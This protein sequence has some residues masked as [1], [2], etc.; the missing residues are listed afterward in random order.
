MPVVRSTLTESDTDMRSTQLLTGALAVVATSA[1][2]G[3]SAPSIAHVP[4]SSPSRS[5]A[6]ASTREHGALLECT[7]TA[8]TVPVRANLYQ[9][10]TYGNFLEVLLNDGTDAETGRSLQTRKPFLAGTQVRAAARVAGHRLVIRGTAKPTGQ[11]RKVHEV[12][13]DAGYRVTS[14]GTHRLLRPRLSVTYGGETGRLSCDRA[15]VFDLKVTKTPIV[16]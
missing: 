2:V 10:R 9:N 3:L 1:L 13:E 7:G 15:F 4:D 11:N 12:I 5:S 14:T 8:G 16:D 6:A